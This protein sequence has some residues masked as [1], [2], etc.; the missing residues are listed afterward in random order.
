ML[1]TPEELLEPFTTLHNHCSPV[2][3]LQPYTTINNYCNH[4]QSPTTM[5]NHEQPFTSIHKQTK[6]ANGPFQVLWPPSCDEKFRK[7]W[8]SMVVFVSAIRTTEHLLRPWCACRYFRL[9]IEA[10][11]AGASTMRPGGSRK[12]GWHMNMPFLSLPFKKSQQL[13]RAG[14]FSMS[15]H[16]MTTLEKGRYYFVRG[17]K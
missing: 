1:L 10:E 13:G 7:V 17:L 8:V 9:W 3:P 5:Y 2:Q 14:V 12:Q 4:S 16:P 11:E 6:Q 15:M